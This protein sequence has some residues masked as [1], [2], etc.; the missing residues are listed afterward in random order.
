MLTLLEQTGKQNGN[1]CIP[2][3]MKRQLKLVVKSRLIISRKYELNECE[4]ERTQQYITSKTL[5]RRKPA[6]W[7]DR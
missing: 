2:T 3:A 6:G 4:K 5:K 1:F 7:N